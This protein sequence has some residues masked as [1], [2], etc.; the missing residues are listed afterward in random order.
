MHE[1][2]TRTVEKLV[3]SI[4][5]L[6]SSTTSYCRVERVKWNEIQKGRR[7]KT[8]RENKTQETH[9]DDVNIDFD[10]PSHPT[11]NLPETDESGKF[12]IK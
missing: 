6:K 11:V 5:L 9:H 7:K 4:R 1:R 3:L 8:G 2:T 10:D 12:V